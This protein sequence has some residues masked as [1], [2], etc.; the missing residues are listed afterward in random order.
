M[1]RV[2]STFTIENVSNSLFYFRFPKLFSSHFP[3]SFATPMPKDLCCTLLPYKCQVIL[4]PH[5]KQNVWLAPL[6][7][8]FFNVLYKHVFLK[9][10]L[11][12]KN[13]S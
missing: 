1:Y 8:F 5:Q 12:T 10:K 11:H 9:I 13:V 7:P 6:F 2:R 3:L 4:L